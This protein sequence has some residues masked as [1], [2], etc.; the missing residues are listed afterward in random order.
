PSLVQAR[1]EPLEREED[2][3]FAD[4]AGFVLLFEELHHRALVATGA[5]RLETRERT[6]RFGLEE[7]DARLVVPADQQRRP[8]GTDT[9]ELGVLLLVIAD[10]AH[11]QLDGHRLGVGD[12]VDLSGKARVVHEYSGVGHQTRG[13]AR[14][15]L[16]DLVDL[17]ETR[18]L[19]ELGV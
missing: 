6:G 2:R 4:H 18:G 11:E 5:R 14:D 7:S 8:E 15:V 9:T 19:R 13:R 3:G 10:L 1:P 16:V 12:S 17:L